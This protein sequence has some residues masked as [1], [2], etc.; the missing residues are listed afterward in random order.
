LERGVSDEHGQVI[1][2]ELSAEQEARRRLAL[3]QIRQWPDPVLK[4]RAEDV[5][6]FDDDLRRLVERMESL[7]GDANGVGLAGNQAG[8]LRRVFVFR[9]ADQPP[10]AAVNPVIVEHSEELAT[11][12]EGCLS[13]QGVLVPVERPAAVTLEAQDVD[14]KPY[15]LELQ[16]LGAR[17]VQHELDHLD[18]VLILERTTSEARREA[19]ATLRPQ[20][21]LG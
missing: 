9:I 14:G 15:R 3:A 19:M 18:G 8:V 5:K 4:L 17:V 16:G 10:R 20:P 6:E 21:I 7:M 12:D 13:L 2:E 1:D 11:D